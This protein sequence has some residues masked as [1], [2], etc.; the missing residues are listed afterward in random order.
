MVDTRKDGAFGDLLP[1][2]E[3]SIVVVLVEPT[4]ARNVGA[5]ARA[6]SNLAVRD[7]R[8]VSP[9][10]FDITMAKG[11]ACWGDDVIENS[12]RFDSLQEA[13][14]D[15]HEVVG[16]ASDSSGHRVPQATLE[17][18]TKTLADEGRRTIGLVF[19]SE[20]NGLSK[21]DF[22]LCQY[23]IRIPSSGMNRSYNLAQS[24][25]L[26]LYQIRTRANRYVGR[27]DIEWSTSA[28]VDE[29]T[30]MVLKVAERAGFLNEHSPAHIADLLRNMTRRGKLTAK[31][32]KLLTGLFGMIRKRL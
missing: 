1:A 16:F 12:K 14:S 32:L 31:E 3:H 8:L 11:V 28:Q 27:G 26:A 17:E 6:M 4:D 25:L 21:A 5:V 29:L 18:W 7:L 23:L 2:S 22:P 30:A 20:D 13:V 15:C 19:G 24:V 10:A 9:R